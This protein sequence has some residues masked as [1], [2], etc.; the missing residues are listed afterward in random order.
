MLVVL[1][2]IL[3]DGERS[4]FWELARVLDGKGI[5]IYYAFEVDLLFCLAQL[6]LRR[7]VRALS[8]L[9]ALPL[10]HVVRLLKNELGCLRNVVLDY[11]R[12][13]IGVLL[14]FG[15]PV[16]LRAH[17]RRVSAP[18][19]CCCRYGVVRGQLLKRRDYCLRR[20]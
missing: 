19:A 3:M 12:Q 10:L 1:V 4:L 18:A 13:V 7:G 11:V 17:L 16:D 20:L 2:A 15:N 9:L 14:L 6:Q 8:R 5:S